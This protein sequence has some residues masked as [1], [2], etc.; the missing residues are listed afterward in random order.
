MLR[1]LTADQAAGVRALAAAAEAADGVSPL[2]EGAHLA[3]ER[4]GALH[5]LEAGCYAQLDPRDATAQLVVAPDSRRHGKATALLASLR[6]VEPAVRLW[7]FGNLPAAQG[8]A[9]AHGLRPI[10]GL[11]ML[12][13]ALVDLPPVPVPPDVEI[14]PLRPGEEDAF[15]AL[16]AAAFAGHPEQGRFSRAD[17]DARR[18]EPWFDPDGLLLARRGDDLLG[19][20]W[21]KRHDEAVGEVYVIATSPA[22]QGSGV[23]KALLDAGLRHLADRGCTEVILYVD[24]ANNRAVHM[25]E[26][27]G[28]GVRHEDMLYGTGERP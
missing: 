18:A 24:S 7:A 3:L 5:L 12:G 22:A 10:R 25:Y 6:A 4:E 1:A 23:G 13:R 17:L 19:F 14:S 27:T 15:L 11:K 20:H 8:F 9:A 26:R 2:N 21:T 28:F 16:N